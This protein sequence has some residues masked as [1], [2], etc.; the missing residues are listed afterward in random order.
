MN[1]KSTEANSSHK[2]SYLVTGQIPHNPKT[3][4]SKIYNI[5]CI[6]R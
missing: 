5:E 3:T 4:L 6:I 2:V 1:T